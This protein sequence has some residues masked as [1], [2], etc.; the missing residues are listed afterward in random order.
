MRTTRVARG[1]GPHGLSCSAH[2]VT[3]VTAE[4]NYL[5]AVRAA[6]EDEL[7]DDPRVVLLGEDIGALGGAFRATAGLLERFGERRV[8]DTPLAEAAIVGAAIGM[9]VRGMRPIAELQFAD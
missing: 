4:V 7:T 6:L 2:V 3:Q 8:I 1:R 5:E 9:A